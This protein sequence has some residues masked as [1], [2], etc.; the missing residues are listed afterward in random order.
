MLAESKTA[1]HVLG[2]A[3]PTEI[4]CIKF[5][6][7]HQIQEKK[8]KYSE[9]DMYSS[10]SFT[11]PHTHISYLPIFVTSHRKII[12]VNIVPDI[13]HKYINKNRTISVVN[14]NR[15]M[16]VSRAHRDARSE[17]IVYRG[18]DATMSF[19][20]HRRTCINLCHTCRP[21]QHALT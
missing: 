1:F 18:N 16:Y 10:C 7:I 3:I 19:V 6:S 20:I 14:A 17:H 12:S 9:L 4:T 2:I 15:Y 8:R 11:H 5:E 13:H 21:R